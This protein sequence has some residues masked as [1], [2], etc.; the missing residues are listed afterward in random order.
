MNLSR[1][2]KNNFS[3]HGAAAAGYVANVY[4]SRF[5]YLFSTES[6]IQIVKISRF[7][8]HQHSSFHGQFPAH[9]R[10]FFYLNIAEKDILMTLLSL[11]S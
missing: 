1:D 9:F 8:Q 6:C 5:K 2:W 7:P 10:F 3:Q 11:H 4:S